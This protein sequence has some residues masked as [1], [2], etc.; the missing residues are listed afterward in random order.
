MERAVLWALLWR[1]ER[2][3][4]TLIVRNLGSHRERNSK[5]FMLFTMS[6]ACV[7]FGGV[8]FT[9][10]STSVAHNIRIF[11]GS[12]VMVMTSNFQH[13]LD[14]PA[15]DRFL[16]QQQR[17]GVV[18][19]WSYATFPLRDY[20]QMDSSERLSTFLG[21]PTRN[22]RVVAVTPE[23]LDTVYPEYVLLDE[24]D[25]ALPYNESTT[26][27][28]DVIRSMYQYPAS[29]AL[30]PS[31]RIYTGFRRTSRSRHSSTKNTMW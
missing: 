20:P 6:V 3:L 2:R 4:K 8:L 13:P 21:F 1:S 10:L 18:G 7:I 16:S 31:K 24:I 28:K 22:Q 26:G 15:L 14:R 23:Y 29:T 30:R 19:T 27:V 5:S 17:E 9:L 25:E 12:D 11:A